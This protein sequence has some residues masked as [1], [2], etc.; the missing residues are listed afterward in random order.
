MKFKDTKVR[1]NTN[2][3]RILEYIDVLTK[4]KEYIDIVF[5]VDNLSEYICGVNFP[6]YLSQNVI[7]ITRALRKIRFQLDII[8]L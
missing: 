4:Y 7:E 8:L 1:I 3:F 2:G 5:S 6:K